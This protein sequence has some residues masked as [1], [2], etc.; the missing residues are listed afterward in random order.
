M[1]YSLTTKKAVHGCALQTAHLLHA[2]ADNNA[3][4]ALQ[5][6]ESVPND[7]TLPN[8]FYE[9]IRDMLLAFKDT[10]DFKSI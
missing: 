2:A 3:E 7:Q 1:K 6:L 9:V 5:V 4:K 10:P 8:E